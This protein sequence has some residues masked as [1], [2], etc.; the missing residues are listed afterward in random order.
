MLASMSQPFSARTSRAGKQPSSYRVDLP[1]IWIPSHPPSFIGSMVR[2]IHDASE[3]FVPSPDAQ[4]TTAIPAP[5]DDLICH[6]DLAPWNLMI[7]DR[8]AFI[9]WDAAAPST[10]L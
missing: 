6:N 3:S 9:D 10:R 2:A 4:W 1:L 7:G 8:W 5:G